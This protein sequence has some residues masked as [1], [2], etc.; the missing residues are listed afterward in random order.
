MAGLSA[1]PETVTETLADNFVAAKVEVSALPL[2]LGAPDAH[3]MM[4]LTGSRT[5]LCTL[6]LGFAPLFICRPGEPHPLYAIFA[7]RALLTSTG[8]R[9]CVLLAVHPCQH[10][11]SASAA[12]P[13]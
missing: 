13:S 3:Q 7:Q 9:T 4:E 6:T 8:P 1:E 2:P 12:A 5:H 10:M 11:V